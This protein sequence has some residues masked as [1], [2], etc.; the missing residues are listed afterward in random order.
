MFPLTRSVFHVRHHYAH[1]NDRPSSLVAYR[2]RARLVPP[3]YQQM[4][5]ELQREIAPIYREQKEQIDKKEFIRSLALSPES[6][7]KYFSSYMRSLGL[8]LESDADIFHPFNFIDATKLSKDY[9]TQLDAINDIYLPLHDVQAITPLT[10]IDCV[11]A[12]AWLRVT[13]KSKYK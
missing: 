6:P 11:N 8:P 1:N 10:I 9:M 12:E 7:F 13:K 4:R 5:R 3:A 2:A